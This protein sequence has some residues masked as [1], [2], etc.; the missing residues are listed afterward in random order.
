MAKILATINLAY[1]WL[2]KTAKNEVVPKIEY[3]NNFSKTLSS[4]EHHNLASDSSN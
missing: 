2:M 1:S 3:Q 4:L